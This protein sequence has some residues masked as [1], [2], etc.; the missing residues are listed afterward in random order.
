M[1]TGEG[2]EVNDAHKKPRTCE[3]RKCVRG[4][5]REEDADMCTN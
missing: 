2:T 5:C 3:R 1:M 4:S